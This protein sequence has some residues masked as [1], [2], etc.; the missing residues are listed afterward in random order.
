MMFRSFMR[1]IHIFSGSMAL[2]TIVLFMSSTILVEL[3]GEVSAVLWVKKMIVYALPLLIL[4]MMGVGGSGSFL[5][6]RSPRGLAAQKRRR[7]KIVGFNGVLILGPAA[8]FLAW[9]AQL[10]AFDL[11]FYGVQVIEIIAGGFNI[12]LLSLNMRDGLQMAARRKTAKRK[13][14]NRSL[15]SISSLHA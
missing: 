3:F 15:S 4:S 1:C 6:G 9:R 14:A 5:A 8:F 2:A 13:Q 10:G 11:S 12:A 7:M